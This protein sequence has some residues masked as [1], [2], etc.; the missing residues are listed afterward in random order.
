MKGSMSSTHK[1]GIREQDIWTR[2]HAHQWIYRCRTRTNVRGTMRHPGVY[3]GFSPELKRSE[4]LHFEFVRAPNGEKWIYRCTKSGD[5]HVVG[6]I[7]EFDR[8]ASEEQADRFELVRPPARASAQTPS[9]SD[10]VSP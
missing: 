6:R 9:T 7:Y 8:K 5:D 2:Q 1:S 3:Y 4:A 10:G